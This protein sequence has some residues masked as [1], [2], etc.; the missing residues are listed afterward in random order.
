MQGHYGTRWLNTWRIGQTLQDGQ[1]AGVVNA[2]ATWAEG[3]GMYASQEGAEAIGRALKSLPADPP[4][5]P[6]FRALVQQ[7]RQPAQRAIAHS[8][9]ADD[10]SDN[11][12]RIHAAAQAVKVGSGAKFTDWWQRILA[13]PEKHPAISVEFAKEARRAHGYADSEVTA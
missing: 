3:L 4:S 2:L 11:R 12:E 6:M 10:R 8:Q 13:H 7:F 1:D 5:L 9:T